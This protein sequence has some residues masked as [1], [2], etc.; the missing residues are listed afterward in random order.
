MEPLLRLTQEL[1]TRKNDFSAEEK[2]ELDAPEVWPELDALL[3]KIE[4]LSQ[5][6]TRLREL[7]VQLSALVI[8]NVVDRKS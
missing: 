5:S 7:V 1:A 4:R 6:N 8:R 2:A 3:G